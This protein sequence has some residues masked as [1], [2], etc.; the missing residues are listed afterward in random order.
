[1]NLTEQDV[2]TYR[3]ALKLQRRSW[4]LLLIYFPVWL[5]WLAMVSFYEWPPLELPLA[6][7]ILCILGATS[8]GHSRSL[9]KLLE[10]LGREHPELSE[11]DDQSSLPIN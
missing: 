2:R 5:A 3:A 7:S 8:F 11:R 9:I 6:T 1:M 10:K 4:L